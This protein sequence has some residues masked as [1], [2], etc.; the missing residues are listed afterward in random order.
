MISAA[1]ST[2][3]ERLSPRSVQHMHR[4]LS[5]SLKQATRWRLL[6]RNPCDDCDPP[7]IER[8][9]MKVWD[10]ETIS[11]ALELSRSWRVHISGGAGDAVRFEAR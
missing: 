2:A 10:V 4:V 11:T 7:R 1:Y 9:D 8:R 6:P 5:Q 3:L